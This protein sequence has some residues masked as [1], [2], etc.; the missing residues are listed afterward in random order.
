MLARMSM[1]ASSLDSS[2]PSRPGFVDFID[3][4]ELGFLSV[5]GRGAAD[6]EA[7]TEAV[8]ALYSVSHSV[9]RLLQQ[10]HGTA[11]R[12]QRLEALWWTEDE[13]P[14]PLVRVAAAGET[15]TMAGDPATWCWQA[16]IRQ[17][18][19]IDA[20]V[21]AQALH[22]ARAPRVPA[23]DSVRYIRWTEG[24]CAQ[25]VYVGPHADQAPTVAR[26]H[27][28]IAEAGRRPRGRHHEL[29]VGDPRR[30]DPDRLRTVLR[31]P[32]EPADG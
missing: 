20:Q 9:Q 22:P 28:A 16:M 14:Q 11:P 31:R 32:V 13:D 26:L 5:T 30:I 3:V 19:P 21:V 27:E 4:P 17:P 25:V 8:G 29:Y 12:M 18:D 6:A 24:R 2:R 10:R 1:T 23:L 7:F 15:A